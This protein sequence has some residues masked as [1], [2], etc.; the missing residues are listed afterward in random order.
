MEDISPEELELFEMEVDDDYNPTHP[1]KVN[2]ERLNYI[3]RER[4]YAIY[5]LIK[6]FDLP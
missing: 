3:L 5:K 2:D 6:D 4:E 1:S